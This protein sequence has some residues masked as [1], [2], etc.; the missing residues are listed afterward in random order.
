[1]IELFTCTG[2]ACVF[3]VLFLTTTGEGAIDPEVATDE[4]L[5][6]LLVMDGPDD[7][8]RCLEGLGL[9]G[10]LGLLE[11]FGFQDFRFLPLK[12]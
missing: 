8:T 6:G 11:K 5:P 2:V 1:M 12:E 7:K 10:L 4:G 3:C 9:L